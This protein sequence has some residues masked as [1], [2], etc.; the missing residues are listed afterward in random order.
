MQMQDRVGQQFGNYSLK[1]LLGSGGYAEVYLAE[2][3]SINSLQRAIKIMKGTGIQDYNQDEFLL[4]ARTIANLQRF[5]PHIVQIHDY[6]VQDSLEDG[7]KSLIPYTVMEYASEGTLRTLYPCGTQVPLDRIVFYVNQ[8][9]AALQ[10]AHNQLPVPITHRDV[11]PENMLLRSI[12]HVL[13]SD[14]GISVTSKTGPQ[15]VAD[16]ASVLGTAAYIA[17]ERFSGHIRRASD[18]YSLAVVVYEWMSGNRPFDGTNAEICMKHLTM[19]PPPLHPGHALITPEIWDVVSRALAK[20]PED[21]FPTV[22]AFAHALE[23]AVEAA[24]RQKRVPLVNKMA[25]HQGMPPTIQASPANNQRQQGSV[26]YTANTLVSHQS[27]VATM[28]ATKPGQPL[29]RKIQRAFELSPQFARD[30]KYRFFRNIGM[31]LNILS[32]L[33]VGWLLGSVVICISALLFSSLAFALCIRAIE[34]KL[35]LFFGGI[36]ALY[37][38]GVGFALGN[39]LASLL[40]SRSLLLALFFCL[41]FGVVSFV[42]HVRYALRK[43]L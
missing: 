14:F 41:V 2:H 23:D 39:A 20:K 37:W 12:D 22:Q 8:I 1:R 25:I 21:R 43:N 13:L 35:A 33:I 3:I 5:N 11:K 24:Q 36:V 17:P 6:G 30:R 16:K 31:A 32:A 29:T 4:E 19:P 38:G 40:H 34:E 26:F 10:C 9:A 18:Q 15:R 42:L 7:Q 28:T 27:Q